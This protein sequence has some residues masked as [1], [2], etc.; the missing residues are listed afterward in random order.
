[1]KELPSL[2]VE[3]ER[4][5]ASRVR[6][7]HM[8]MIKEWVYRD[9]NQKIWYCYWQRVK[10]NWQSG[11]KVCNLL[12]IWTD[13]SL[14]YRGVS[15]FFFLNTPSLPHLPLPPLIS[16]LFTFSLFPSQKLIFHCS[17]LPDSHGLDRTAWARLVPCIVL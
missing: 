11:R 6:V 10:G 5:R 2:L 8:C 9:I 4:E 15:T 17:R 13:E 1:M 14:Y 3:R 12:Q 16:K 7:L